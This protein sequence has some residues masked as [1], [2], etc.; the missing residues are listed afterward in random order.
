[1]V[2][3]SREFANARVEQTRRAALRILVARQLELLECLVET[4][5]LK[6]PDIP[7]AKWESQELASA[8]WR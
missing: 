3:G 6:E 7:S 5:G 4:L 2:V 1:M 8:P